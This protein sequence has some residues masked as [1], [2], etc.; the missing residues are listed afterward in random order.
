MKITLL[1]FLCSFL[2]SG[3][4]SQYYYKDIV[5]PRET[6][7]QLR[8]FKEQKIR[9]V[10]VMSYESD[11]QPS[12]DFQAGQKITDN[13]TKIITLVKSAGGGESEL[14]TVFNTSGHLLKTVDTT[15]GSGS[16]SE[17]FY[18]DK[19]Q[20][21]RIVN[22]STSGGQQK[23]KEEHAWFYNASGK[24]EKMLRIKN[25]S[26][27]TYI[28]FI[29]D[30]KGNVAE[31]NSVRKGIALP[32]FY[33]YYDGNDRLT[34]I[35]SYSNKARRLLPVYIFDYNDNGFVKSRMVVPEGVDD[36]Q[37]WYYEYDNAGMK[38]KETCFN[39]KKQMLGRVGYVYE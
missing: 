7:E 31:E 34:D 8:K 38:V 23:E 35:V 17:Y 5:V 19:G 26:D 14:T 36:Y 1:V 30:E 20:L 18:D 13:F 29:P 12:E 4:F 39:K 9:S 15:D 22:V 25:N 27:T 11:G 32:S 6:M 21:A 37:K 24:P 28:S 2:C 3:V 16:V 10:K 33:Y